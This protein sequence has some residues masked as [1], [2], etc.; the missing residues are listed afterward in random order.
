MSLAALRG[1]LK[2]IIRKE[3]D[4]EVMGTSDKL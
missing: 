2:D 4:R 1:V 3:G